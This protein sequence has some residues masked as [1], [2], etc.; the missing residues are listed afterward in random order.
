METDCNNGKIVGVNSGFG[1][2]YLPKQSS[3][4]IGIPGGLKHIAMDEDL[5][6]W[7]ANYYN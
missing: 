4:W 5:T 7:G 6:V 1:I 3:G 2:F